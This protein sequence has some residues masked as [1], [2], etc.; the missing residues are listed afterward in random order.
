VNDSP[1]IDFE[2]S[3]SD[4]SRLRHRQHKYSHIE[5]SIFCSPVG[6]PSQASQ[7]AQPSQ[8]SSHSMIAEWCDTKHFGLYLMNSGFSIQNSQRKS[9]IRRFQKID[10]NDQYFEPI[11]VPQSSQRKRRM[12][13]N[14][15]KTYS[16]TLLKKKNP[17]KIPFIVP[18]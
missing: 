4:I 17:K 11:F 3:E 6:I 8:R 10:R 9:S 16:S 7:S 14:N 1:K 5:K 13:I 2:L 12:T 18:F 15:L